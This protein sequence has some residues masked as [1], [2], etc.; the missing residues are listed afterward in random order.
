MRRLRRSSS[1]LGAM[2]G[3]L[4]AMTA[5]VLATRDFD[6][7]AAAAEKIVA[8]TERCDYCHVSEERKELGVLYSEVDM[9]PPVTAKG[10]TRTWQQAEK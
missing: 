7:M 6:R 1:V 2:V 8:A 9:Y 4:I 3:V 5:T 10:G